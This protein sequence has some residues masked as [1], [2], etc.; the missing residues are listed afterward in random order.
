MGGNEPPVPEP[1]KVLR[2]EKAVGADIAGEI[3]SGDWPP[4]R[5][6]GVRRGLDLT[7]RIVFEGSAFPVEDDAGQD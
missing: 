1:A 5:A 6:V 3:Q 7:Q 2:R 4:G